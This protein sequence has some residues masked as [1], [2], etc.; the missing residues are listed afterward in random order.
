M[1]GLVRSGSIHTCDPY[2]QVSANNP[3][4][5]RLRGDRCEGLYVQQVANTPL[6]IA[7]FGQINIDKTPASNGNLTVEWS[8]RAP[9]S[10]KLRAYGLKPKVYYRMDSLRPKG[11]QSYR[12]PADVLTALEIGK[13]DIGIV[14][15]TEQKIGTAVRDLYVPIRVGPPRLVPANVYD[16]V[17]VPGSEF[18]EIFVSLTALPSDGNP[19]KEIWN[20]KPLGYGY[21]PAGRSITIPLHP[22][23]APGMYLVEL[24]ATLRTGG[25]ITQEIWFIR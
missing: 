1:G 8:A 19:R 21:Y 5:Y 11:S 9:G 20:G 3:F 16:L 10:I 6:F 13:D 24:A 12:W 18:S 25:S 14:A 23:P 22:L 2:L 7:S 4:A 15:W 17:V